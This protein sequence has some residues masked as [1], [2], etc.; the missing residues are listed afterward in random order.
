MKQ[1]LDI[2]PT[3]S[4]ILCIHSVSKF[5]LLYMLQLRLH[6]IKVIVSSLT[7]HTIIVAYLFYTVQKGLYPNLILDTGPFATK[8]QFQWLFTMRCRSF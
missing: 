1:E 7:E 3:C 6:K 8:Q 4:Y 2:D 5:A